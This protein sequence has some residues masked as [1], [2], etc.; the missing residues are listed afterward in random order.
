MSSIIKQ[1]VGK[2][3]YLYESISYRNSEGKPRN[4]RE[5]VGKIDPITKK[6][7][8]KPEYIARRKAEGNPIEVSDEK[9]EFSI[10]EIKQ[11]HIKE[12]GCFYLLKCIAEKISL[13]STIKDTLLKY[14]NEV[15]A[16]SSYLVATGDPFLYCEDW[17]NKIECLPI[18]SL[19]SQRISELLSS[20]S[21]NERESFYREWA[22]KRCEDEYLALDITSISS[23]SELIDDVEWGYNRDKENLPQINMCLLTGEKSRLPI[24]QT[25]YSGSLKD[26]TTLKTTLAKL[27]TNSL[28]K[29]ILVVMDKGFYSTKN[30][31]MMLKDGDGFKF[32]ISVP[33]TTKFAKDQVKSEVKDI[34]SLQNTIVYGGD[35]I[36]G[37]T[38]TRSWSK[39]HKIFT[40]IYYNAVKATKTK[41]ELYAH[42]TV[43]KSLAEA[44]PDNKEYQDEF[45]KY[46]IIR[47]S[48]KTSSGYTVNIK[49]NVV[50][51]ELET[52]G[53]MV[54]ISNEVQDAKK[55]LA[56]YRDKDIVE[57]GFL[58]LKNNLELGRLRVHKEESMQNK[59]FV[60][61]ISLILMSHIHKVMA[62]KNLYKKMTMKKLLLTLSKL[63][64]QH[65]NGTDILYPL[66]KDQKEIF[67]AFDVDLPQ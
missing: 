63:R 34:D 5:V 6:E 9:T 42:V 49:E 54:I 23:Y 32:I 60:S 67:E 52:A 44:D 50:K 10:D 53:W 35:S 33:F 40:H 14:C 39:E 22:K 59:I 29:S 64:I 16:L 46:L 55:A 48:E 65:I 15:F 62:E 27:K 58:K 4:T 19:S 1:K 30:I 2:H 38:K 13:F 61:F 12:Y 51:A 17:I 45:E 66:T 8:Y 21:H 25:V 20:I 47:K 7:I 3:T 24:Y 31:N 37:V 18:G 26:V 11:S 41:E 43:L 56:V 36:R 28:D 57:K